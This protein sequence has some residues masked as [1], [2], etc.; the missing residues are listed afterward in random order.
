MTDFIFWKDYFNSLGRALSRLADVISH[1]DV[2]TIDFMQDAAIQRFEFVIEL[3][4]KVLKKILTY[5][6]VDCTTPR[7]VLRQAYQFKIINDEAMWLAMLD[8][9]N[10]TSHVY[11]EEDAKRVYEHIKIYLPVLENTYASLKQLYHL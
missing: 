9:R 7:D 1:K 5:E 3:Y 2:D 6:K 10:N 8:D 11:K 4:W